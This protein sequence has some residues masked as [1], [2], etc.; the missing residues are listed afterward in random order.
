MKTYKVSRVVYYMLINRLPGCLFHR[1]DNGEYF[2]KPM[3]QYNSVIELA[4]G[5][6]V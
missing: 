6:E 1:E 5:I 2:V 4:G 3:K